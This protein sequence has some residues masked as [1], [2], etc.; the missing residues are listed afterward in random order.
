LPNG[1]YD[2]ICGI[3]NGRQPIVAL[4][5]IANSIGIY[6]WDARE[7]CFNLVIERRRSDKRVISDLTMVSAFNNT[8]ILSWQINNISPKRLPEC[9]VEI[10]NLATGESRILDFGKPDEELFSVPPHLVDLKK[11]G[12]YART[13]IK[14]VSL[15]R[16]ALGEKPAIFALRLDLTFTDT[17]ADVFGYGVY[18]AVRFFEMGA[19]GEG[20]RSISL[21]PELGER[22]FQV[23]AAAFDATTSTSYF[24]VN[25]AKPDE[26]TLE[27]PYSCAVIKVP[28]EGAWH[29][30][31][32][33]PIFFQSSEHSI[34]SLTIASDSSV[35]FTEGW[36]DG[37]WTRWNLKRWDPS[38]GIV[39]DVNAD[40]LASPRVLVAPR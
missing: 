24:A 10:L 8:A 37:D 36:Y 6:V 27:T 29:R 16:P 4:G 23:T 32:N 7:Y 34:D 14:G 11:P 28:S 20:G 17:S 18:G 19:D 40:W 3:T 39:S 5:D 12:L 25:Y 33:E 31:Y 13:D 26:T 15:I 1:L 38:T 22:V 21:P 2:V 35:W 30:I 9:E